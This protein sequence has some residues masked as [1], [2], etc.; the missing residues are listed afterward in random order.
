MVA[1]VAVDE[2]GEAS[3]AVAASRAVVVDAATTTTTMAVGKAITTGTKDHT[4]VAPPKDRIVRA[5]EATTTTRIRPRC[6]PR[7]K[8]AQPARAS[9]TLL[10]PAPSWYPCRWPPTWPKDNRETVATA[11]PL[12]AKVRLEWEAVI[13][14]LG[15]DQKAARR[16]ACPHRTQAGTG[17]PFFIQSRRTTSVVTMA[18]L[19]VYIRR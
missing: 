6:S 18:L 1:D 17:Q 4:T 12:V 7:N 10:C 2:A 11:Q 13:P 15:A 19:P 3:K 8:A 14:T 9:T 16:G 5:T